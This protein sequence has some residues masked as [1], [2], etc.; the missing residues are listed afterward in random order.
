MCA[1]F[2][3]GPRLTERMTQQTEAYVLSI[4]GFCKAPWPLALET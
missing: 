3:L 4:E 1:L 2:C